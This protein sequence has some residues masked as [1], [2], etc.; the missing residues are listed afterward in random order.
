[1]T[2]VYG[3][4]VLTI[5]LM[6]LRSQY[7]RDSNKMQVYGGRK[8]KSQRFCDGYNKE[9]SDACELTTIEGEVTVE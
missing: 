6:I 2:S 3:A 4:G 1:M 9:S 7:G 8:E 5:K